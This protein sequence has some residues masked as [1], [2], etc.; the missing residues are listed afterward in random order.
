MTRTLINSWTKKDFKLDWFSGS[1]AGG[2]HRNKHQNC[3]RIT[4]IESGITVTGQ[5]SKERKRNF[6]EAF[7]RLAHKIVEHYHPKIPKPRAPIT[8]TIRTYNIPDNRVKDHA[9]GF[10]MAWSD[11]D[12]DTMIMARKRALLDD[13]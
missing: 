12:I 13:L 7:K 6:D 8:E 5:G 2:Q 4:H 3:V 1:G 10:E 9:S 11:L